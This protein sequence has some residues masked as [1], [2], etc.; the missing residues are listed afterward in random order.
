[1]VVPAC[2]LMYTRPKHCALLVRHVVLFASY[3]LVIFW[4][5]CLPGQLLACQQHSHSLTAHRSIHLPFCAYCLT[6]LVAVAA[7]TAPSPDFVNACLHFQFQ[8]TVCSI[9]GLRPAQL[10]GPFSLCNHFSPWV[11]SSLHQPSLLQ[12]SACLASCR[13]CCRM[14][15]RFRNAVTVQL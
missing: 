6:R 3:T 8:L 11:H 10:Q 13:A 7:A 5:L 14:S 1:M 4:L 12:P 9:N 15:Y 2:L